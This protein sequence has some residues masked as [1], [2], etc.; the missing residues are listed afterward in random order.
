MPLIEPSVAPHDVGS[1]RTIP[2]TSIVG[3]PLTVTT[4]DAVA[5]QVPSDTVKSYVPSIAVVAAALT[6]GLWDVLV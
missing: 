1:L 5:V 2:V 3:D 6:V 4:V